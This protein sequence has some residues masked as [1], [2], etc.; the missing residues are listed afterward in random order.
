MYLFT[1]TSFSSKN[2]LDILPSTP[3]CIFL[4][5]SC[6]RKHLHRLATIPGEK[7]GLV[8]VFCDHCSLETF[9]L[10]L[11]IYSLTNSKCKSTSQSF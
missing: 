2:V 1:T 5:M 6:I 7:Y 9:S 3:P 4:R 11:V 8:Y 10:C